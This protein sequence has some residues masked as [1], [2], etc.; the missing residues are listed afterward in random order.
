MTF[1]NRGKRLWKDGESTLAYVTPDHSFS[2][3]K[4]FKL[5]SIYWP[6]DNQSNISISKH[7]KESDLVAQKISKLIDEEE[8]NE[9][10]MTKGKAS[11]AKKIN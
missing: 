5:Y 1:F 2:K 11:S 9:L 4:R 6:E 7:Q 8:K 3:E 10:R